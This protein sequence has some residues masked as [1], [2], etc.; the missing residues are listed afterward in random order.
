MAG[1][2]E[3]LLTDERTGIA[4]KTCLFQEDLLSCLRLYPYLYVKLSKN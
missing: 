1:F 3:K 4:K 2:Q